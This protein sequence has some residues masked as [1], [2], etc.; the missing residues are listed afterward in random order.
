MTNTHDEKHDEKE[1]IPMTHPTPLVP[2]RTA[3]L[4]MDLQA[5][6][7]ALVPDHDELL[8][9]VQQ[10]RQAAV[11]AGVEV[12]HVRV[13]FTPG[14]HAAVP[15]RNKIFAPAAEAGVFA[16]DSPEAA[17]HP[18]AQPEP[19]E[20]VFTKTRVGALSTTELH[21]HLAE[22]GID[23]LV[24]AGISTSGVVLSTLRD[25]ADRD[26]RLL[27]LRDVCADPDPEVHRVLTDSVFPQQADVID[28]K[29]FVDAL[30][31][32]SAAQ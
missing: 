22:R 19:G 13:G 10:V 17:F 29:T 26:Y 28:A 15:S 23:T 32:A 18:D 24:L 5:G 30:S 14:D 11:S 12:A 27:V 4:L 21:G 1:D 31:E 3:L 7:L 8:R 6:I 20:H 9:S 2:A 16:V 25:A